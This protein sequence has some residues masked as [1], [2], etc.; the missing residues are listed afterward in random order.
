M[1]IECKLSNGTN[2]YKT[3]YINNF[4][5]VLFINDDFKSIDIYTAIIAN[6]KKNDKENIG[7]IDNTFNLEVEFLIYDDKYSGKMDIIDIADGFIEEIKPI[8]TVWGDQCK[9]LT[10][11]RE[12]STCYGELYDEESNDIIERLDTIP[13]KK[14]CVRS[15]RTKHNS[16]I[17]IIEKAEI[18]DDKYQIKTNFDGHI[19][20]VGILTWTKTTIP[21]KKKIDLSFYY[22]VIIGNNDSDLTRYI[23]KDISAYYIMPLNY[24][25]I[26]YYMKCWIS[27]DEPQVI[28]LPTI[29]QQ[30]SSPIKEAYFTEWINKKI[31]NKIY[32]RLLP[33]EGIK[34]SKSFE[35]YLNLVSEK[36]DR[37]NSIIKGVL[38]SCLFMFGTIKE[39]MDKMSQYFFLKFPGFD[40]Y[41]FIISLFLLVSLFIKP[42]NNNSLNEKKH[43]CRRRW[44]L[45]S[46]LPLIVWIFVALSLDPNCKPIITKVFIYLPVIFALSVLSNFCIFR[47]YYDFT[48]FTSIKEIWEKF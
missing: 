32:Y 38:I 35:M 34:N 31:E 36:I 47:K 1:K 11:Q 4:Y 37:I 25:M 27:T 48:F 30:I 2:T 44:R 28:N 22:K 45:F 39:N 16:S 26:N 10:N 19:D 40:I 41:W 46:Y 29:L 12:I 23:I 21:F 33:S 9:V 17:N 42:L 24:T 8:Q 14:M 6:G 43:L 20:N 5:Q 18:L 15:S 13:E 7:M 3:I